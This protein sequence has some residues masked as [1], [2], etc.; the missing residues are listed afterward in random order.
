MDPLRSVKRRFVE[1]NVLTEGNGRTVKPGMDR[2]VSREGWSGLQRREGA[3]VLGWLGRE[4]RL[5]KGLDALAVGLREIL[6]AHVRSASDAR[7]VWEAVSAVIAK[8][9]EPETYSERGANVAYAW[10]HLLVRYVRTWLALEHLLAHGLLPM[11]KYGVRVLDVGTGPGPSALA[12]HDFY[13]ALT[14]YA[15]SVGGV[16]WQQPSDV[17]C[18]ERCGAMNHF[19]HVLSET[20]ALNGAPQSIL[21]MA[22]GLSD[23]ATVRPSVERRELERRLRN[24]Y[25]GYY[26]ELGEWSDEPTHTAEE[27]NREANAHRRY[28]LFTFSNFLTTLDTVSTFQRN[29]EDLLTDAQPGSVLLMI[30]GKGN[31]YAE[32]R[33]RMARLAEAGGFRRGN[34][35]VKVGVGDARVDGRLAEEARWFHGRLK[36]LAGDLPAYDA[37]TRDLLDELEGR[38]RMSF[39]ASAVHAFRK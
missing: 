12:T 31:D 29:L 38:K 35:S 15:R 7:E 3:A 16:R 10:L 33:K 19:R 27:A 20:L 21:A 37:V 4:E 26:D 17:T 34:P 6:N 11:G 39:G 5:G 18:V 1:L 22:S 32:I 23:F 2:R 36:G 25:D 8:C 28:K 13:V 9:N 14:G 24:Q 30:G